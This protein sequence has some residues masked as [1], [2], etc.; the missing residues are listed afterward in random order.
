[1]MQMI[2]MPDF[3]ITEAVVFEVTVITSEGD[4][5]LK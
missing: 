2:A 4:K 3:Q 5:E 1:M